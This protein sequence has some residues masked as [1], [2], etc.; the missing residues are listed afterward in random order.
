MLNEIKHKKLIQDRLASLQ[1]SIGAGGVY[2]PPDLS[3]FVFLCG[4]NKPTREV[5]ERRKALMEFAQTHLPHTRFFIAEKMFATLQE[6]GHKGNLLDVEQ[7]ISDFSDY[8]LIVLESPSSFAELGAFSHKTL[9]E[10]LIVINDTKFI[11]EDSFINLGPVAAIKE[12][13]GSERILDY[14]MSDDGVVT[15][16]AIGDTFFGLHDLLKTPISTRARTAKLDALHPGKNFNKYSAM[17]LHDIVYLTGPLLYKEII[18]VLLR[19]FGKANF[20]NVAHMLAILSA[21]ESVERNEKGLYRSKMEGFYFQFS[22]DVGP[23]VATFRN[24]IQRA[25]PDRLYAY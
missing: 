17:F 18:E 19:L 4:A 13:V 20:N 24:Y 22:F 21:F 12:S 10:K 15:K 8:V 3:S 2:F 7:L 16:D 14:K 5:S 6:E 11:H 9:R 25:Y 23:I 1:R